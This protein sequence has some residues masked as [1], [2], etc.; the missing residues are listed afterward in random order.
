M[1]SLVQHIDLATTSVPEGVEPGPSLI[2]VL[3]ITEWSCI[4]FLAYNSSSNGK[5]TIR[6]LALSTLDIVENDNLEL[7][8]PSRRLGKLPMPF[9]M[10]P[11]SGN[12]YFGEL[13]WL[14]CAIYYMLNHLEDF[15][16]AKCKAKCPQ[17]RFAELLGFLGSKA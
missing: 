7:E 5:D 12:K 14:H 11:P 15:F 4:F 3:C 16:K 2:E 13:H 1:H 9:I 8:R 10:N 6:S 17:G